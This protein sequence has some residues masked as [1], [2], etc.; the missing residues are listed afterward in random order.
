IVSH[1]HTRTFNTYFGGI[2]ASKWFPWMITKY[3]N[4]HTL[5]EWRQ[6]DMQYAA[7]DAEPVQNFEQTPEGRDYLSKILLFRIFPWSPDYQGPATLFYRLWRPQVTTEFSFTDFTAMP[8]PQINLVGYDLSGGSKQ[9]VNGS[10]LSPGGDYLF[11]FYWK[12][13]ATPHLDYSV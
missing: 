5:E 8:Q 11:T 12:T 3:L 4:D 2:S 9:P 13:L 1:S 6:M 10:T 7:I